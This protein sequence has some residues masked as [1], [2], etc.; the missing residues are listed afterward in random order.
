M[1]FTLIA[2]RTQIHIKLLLKMTKRTTAVLITLIENMDL[3]ILRCSQR[4]LGENS[5]LVSHESHAGEE[6]AHLQEKLVV[7]SKKK[8]LSIV[9]KCVITLLLKTIVYQMMYTWDIPPC[10][11]VKTTNILNKVNR[12][13]FSRVLF[14]GIMNFMWNKDRSLSSLARASYCGGIEHIKHNVTTFL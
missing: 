5:V 11:N 10:H 7:A 13:R 4:T 6:V 12:H 8:D 1:L 3:C 9:S 2:S 14:F